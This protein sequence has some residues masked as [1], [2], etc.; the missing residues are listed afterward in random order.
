MWHFRILFDFDM[1]TLKSEKITLTPLFQFELCKGWFLSI[2]IS[3][4]PIQY[5]LTRGKKSITFSSQVV[6]DLCSRNYGVRLVK[7]RRQMH[8]PPSVLQAFIDNEVFLKWYDPNIQSKNDLE[9]CDISDQSNFSKES[10]DLHPDIY[11]AVLSQ[12]SSVGF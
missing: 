12:S 8:L 11:K 10:H 5:A 9:S 7:G 4:Q 6:A 1:T 3:S 2:D